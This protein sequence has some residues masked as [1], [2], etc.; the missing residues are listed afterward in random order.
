MRYAADMPDPTWTPRETL[1]ILRNALDGFN[2]GKFIPSTLHAW[3]VGAYRPPSEPPRD[4]PANVPHGL[5]V[6]V[7]ALF[8]QIKIHWS[9]L[10]TMLARHDAG[11]RSKSSPLVLTPQA[12][13]LRRSG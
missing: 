8:L 2:A 1:H 4:H 9:V 12:S 11:E 13:A 5:A 7:T 6:V 3:L 10:A